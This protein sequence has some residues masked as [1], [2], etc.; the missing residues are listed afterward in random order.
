MVNLRNDAEK[1]AQFVLVVPETV[2]DAAS[3][4]IDGGRS[5]YNFAAVVVFR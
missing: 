2:A 1:L 5:D 3:Y 4:E